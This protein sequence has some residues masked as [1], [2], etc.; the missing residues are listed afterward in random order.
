MRL[1]SVASGSPTGTRTATELVGLFAVLDSAAP[2]GY[3][4]MGDPALI[5]IV[6]LAAK[7]LVVAVYPSLFQ[8]DKHTTWLSGLLIVL[9]STGCI[10]DALSGTF[11]PPSL[12]R[13][14]AFSFSLIFTL[15]ILR[16]ST[17]FSYCRFFIVV[18]VI[19]AFAHIYLCYSGAIHFHFGRYF[20][21]GQSHPNLGGEI[22]AMTAIAAAIGF[23]FRASIPIIL[24][25][26]TSCLLMQSR[27]ALIVI[28]LAALWVFYNA[29][30][31][32]LSS[33]TIIFT[34]LGLAS[35]LYLLYPDVLT[36]FSDLVLLANDTER[37]LGTGFVGRDVRWAS[38][39]GIFL[40][41]PLIGAGIS[42][43]DGEAAVA[44]HNAFLYS[45]AQHG[46]I[47]VL[48]W[49]AFFA[50][51]HRAIKRQRRF[52]LLL[53]FCFILLI[54]NDRFINLNIYP[55]LM[56]VIFF[57]FGSR[58]PLDEIERQ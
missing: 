49:G 41:N 2:V 4:I 35:V 10:A 38:G 21:V 13:Y 52:A 40:E 25:L 36:Q 5:Q 34:I 28:L 57:Y 6:G 54:F 31:E 50:S 17:I 39:F 9:T 48:F 42:A 47:S 7:C 33:R 11:S 15:S 1:H 19:T 27:A 29:A 37:G 23:R 55:F 12:Y 24:T 58:C 26:A 16:H 20:Y 56:Y 45:I 51:Y 46:I 30:R 44:P 18:P 43:F 22:S 32:H 8:L 3:L 53:S 14:T